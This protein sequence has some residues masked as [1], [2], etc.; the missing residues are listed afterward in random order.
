MIRVMSYHDDDEADP[1][2]KRPGPAPR[3]RSAPSLDD[4]V[5]LDE[6]DVVALLEAVDDRE[7]RFEVLL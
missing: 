1:G 7:V 6:V 2:P 4:H 3:A 5:V